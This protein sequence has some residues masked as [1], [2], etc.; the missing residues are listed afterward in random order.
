MKAVIEGFTGCLLG[1][2]I[3][4]ALGYPIEFLK[5]DEIYSEYGE[6]GIQNLNVNRVMGKSLISD[7]TQMTLFT[8]DG[9]L[10]YE[11][12]KEN[13][14]NI[15]ISECTF[16]SYE[17]WLYTQGQPLREEYSWLIEKDKSIL[18]KYKELFS[19]RAPGNSC[20]TSLIDAKNN[21]YGT[22]KKHVNNSKGCGGVMRVAP[23]GLYNLHNNKKAF[24]LGC[25][26]AAITH[27]HPTG[28]LSSGA[29]ASIISD[30]CCGYSIEDAV[31]NVIKILEN[32]DD[33]EETI[34]SLNKAI[35]FAKLGEPSA[36]KLAELGEGWI[37]EEA[38]AIAVYCALSYPEN[39]EEALKLSVNHNGDSD[40]TGSIC[41]NIMGAKLGISS[42]PQRWINNLELSDLIK[43]TAEKL[44]KCKYI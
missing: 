31:K 7:D 19:Q 34:N 21:N 12:K 35:T 1:G 24:K 40:S 18:F 16:Y 9:I 27:G 23:A 11:R 17:R 10:C 20:L 38:L 14:E 2:A 3:G 4:D 44:Y 5:I 36:K 8:A 30:V 37:A 13:G 39:F 22:I 43:G 41:G 29:F 6:N 28:Y 42:I 33:N 15:C 32:M 26:L 25:E